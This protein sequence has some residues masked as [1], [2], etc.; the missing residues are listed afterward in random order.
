MIEEINWIY[1]AGTTV[2]DGVNEK[3]R[4]FSDNGKFDFFR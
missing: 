1:R 2:C 3:L 4:N